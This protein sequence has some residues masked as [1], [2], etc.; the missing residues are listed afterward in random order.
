VDNL[1]LTSGTFNFVDDGEDFKGQ[2]PTIADEEEEEEEA[3]TPVKRSVIAAVVPAAAPAVAQTVDDEADDAEP[4]P[5]PKKTLSA[6]I[7]VKKTV[8][9][10]AKAKQ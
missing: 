9:L 1:P 4:I 7:V 3:P 8:K 5:V 10:V 6:P 2:A